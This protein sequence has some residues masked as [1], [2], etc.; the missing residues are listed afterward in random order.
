MEWVEHG[1]LWRSKF[2]LA[3]VADDQMFEQPF[4]RPWEVRHGGERAVQDFELQDHV[5]Q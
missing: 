1:E 4:Q 2:V 5:P 3:V